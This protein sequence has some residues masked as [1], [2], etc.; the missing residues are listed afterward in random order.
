MRLK[1]LDLIKYGKFTD[2]TL[3]FPH[4]AH[5][6]HVIVGPNE[7]GKSTVRTAVSELLFGMRLQ[8]PLDFLHNTPELRIG[9]VLENGTAEQRFHRARGRN[10]LRTPQD[11]KLPDDFLAAFLDGTSKDFFEQMFGL[12]HARLVEGGRSI[13]DASDKLGQVLFES[14]AGVGSLGPVRE[15]LESRAAG[16][17]AA[18]RSGSAYAQAEASFAE[19]TSEL[20]AAQV[21]TRDWVEKK[22]ALEA[23]EQAI[24]RLRADQR[25]LESQRSK[26][27][28]VR[29]LAPYIEELS[30]KQHELAALGEVVDLPPTAHAD[31]L[32]AQA[33]IAAER[34]VQEARQADL[35]G[36]ETSRDAIEPDRAALALA[37]EIDALDTLR[38]ECVNHPRELLVRETEIRNHLDAAFAAAAQLGWPGDEAALR[39][40]LPG[41]LA[42]KTVTNLLRD[43]GLREQALTTAREAHDEQT[44]KLAQLQ[45]QLAHLP[46]IDVPHALHAALDDAREFRN[47][48]TKE[49]ALERELADAQRTVEEKCQLLGQWSKPVPALRA[50]D[51]PSATRLAALQKEESE[52]MS[53]VAAAQEAAAAALEDTERFELQE[54]HFTQGN[55]VV[56]TAQV[57]AART[58][59][60]SAWREVKA[61]RVSLAEGA[62]AVDD[63]MRLADELVDAQ[64]GTSQAAATLLNLRQ[65]VETARANA[66][67]KLAALGER[68]RE[69][70]AFRNAW[71]QTA[72]DAQLAG[73]PLADMSAWLA[74]REAA[75][76]AQGECDRRASE[77]EARRAAR[78]A[79]HAALFETLRPVAPANEDDALAT[80]IG[81][82]ETVVQSAQKS[83]VQREGLEAQIRDAE[84]ASASA[85]ARL[86]IEQ[87]AYAKWQT[88]WR[89]ALAQANL[90][91]RA[92][93]LA[94]A[95]GAV[96]L[97]NTIAAA[98]SDAEAPRNRI[99]AI[100]TQLAMLETDARRLAE[101]LAPEWPASSDGIDVARQLAARLAAARE[102]AKSLAQADADVQVA[103]T[104]VADA[105]AAVAGAQARI[106]PILKL[107]GVSEIDAALPLAERSDARRALS[108][109]ISAARDTL[110]RE[111]DG[112]AQE[113]IE[114]EIAEQPI[115]EV[116]ALLATVNQKREA[117]ERALS[118]CL[119]QQVSARQ[120][121]DAINGQANAALAE[122][123]RQ[124]ALSAMGDAAEQYL[125]AA[126]ASRLLKWATDRYRDQKQGPM[127]RRAGEIFSGLTL[128]DFARLVVDNERNPPALYARRNTGKTVEVSGMSEGT[129]DQL[130]LALRIAALELQLVSKAALPFVADDLFINF[131]DERAK[132]GFAAL[133]NLS[134]KT[135][136]LFLTHHDHLLPLIREIFGAQV[137]V[138][139]LQRTPLAA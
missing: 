37:A 12:D 96:E 68:E 20:K 33:D 38:G 90:G 45:Q 44:R 105:A 114:A 92:A 119:Q 41:A 101:A 112:L 102:T 124:E 5:D 71:A 99:R 130:F 35:A 66:Q 133:R 30:L 58:R 139:E 89:E 91:A 122:A 8:T 14:A 80:L 64:L 85:Q 128:G 125:E 103:R 111:G 120:A 74:N 69:L 126:T 27:E 55:K 23:V 78:I 7:A 54:K 84:R 86:T 116:P 67:R 4:A 79:A 88:Q 11:D 109:A 17:W 50:L 134:A 136:V 121:F 82:A 94:A 123:K 6:F 108:K 127:L 39:A 97:A 72:I 40:A 131:D 104:R 19:A 47:S 135:Q 42:R 16:L 81:K 87:E 138:V 110:V 46:G 56:T 95:E 43:H 52:R 113:A 49:G 115:T 3:P 76:N 28:R 51:L 98:F 132:A 73:L 77:L 34:R 83:A 100:R 22:D 61:A 2:T 59:R 26:L 60:D 25:S 57:Q 9:G 15:E 107:A 63:A 75:L 53:A 1:Q 36:K 18:R 70:E 93:T 137:N 62:P 106:E 32:K 65:Q 24:E 31:L 29:R 10:S 118:E 129:R 117:G 21:R 48:A 13:L